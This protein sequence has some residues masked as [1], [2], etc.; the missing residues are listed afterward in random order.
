MKIMDYQR[1][2]ILSDSDRISIKSTHNTQ[3]IKFFE[4]FMD[5][6]PSGEITTIEEARGTI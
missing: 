2:Y 6:S 4:L 1:N 3:I 5:I